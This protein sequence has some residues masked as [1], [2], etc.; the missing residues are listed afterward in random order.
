M[1]EYLIL[2]CF[3]ADSKNIMKNYSSKCKTLGHYFDYER[4][5]VIMGKKGIFAFIPFFFLFGE[6]ICWVLLENDKEQLLKNLSSKNR[7]VHCFRYNL[8]MIFSG[9]SWQFQ[10]KKVMAMYFF[11]NF[12]LKSA[13]KCWQIGFSKIKQCTVLIINGL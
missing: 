9:C 5:L 13:E 4:T 7:A 1:I 3:S 11:S 12:Q 6:G 10:V 8:W 2:Q